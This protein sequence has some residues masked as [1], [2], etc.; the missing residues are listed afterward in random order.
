M[1][2]VIVPHETRSTLLRVLRTLQ[3][4]WIEQPKRRHGNIRL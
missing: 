4:E 3:T 1:D 2:D